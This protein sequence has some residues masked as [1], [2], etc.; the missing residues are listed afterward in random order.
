[1]LIENFNMNNFYMIAGFLLSMYACVSNDIIQTLGTFLSANNKTNFGY[2]WLFASVV[3][4]VTITTGWFVN[5]GDMS[6]GLL[7]RIPVTENFSLLYLLPPII[8]IFLTRWGI[9]VATTFLVLSVFSVSD[10]E[11]IWMMLTKSVLGYI[12]AFFAAIVIYNIIARPLERY[13]YYTQKRSGNNKISKYWIVAKWFSTAFIW[14]QWLVQDSAKLFVYLPR[15]ASAW[16][17]IFVL[18]CFVAYLGILTYNRGG[19]IQ[20]IVKMKTNVQ[21]PRSATIIDIIY[22]CLLLYFIN[23]NNVPMSTTWVFIGLLA[24]REVALYQ[25]LRFESPK[26]MYK[27]ILN[28]LTKV[29]VG[30]VVSIV[31][32]LLL[33]QY[34]SIIEYF[35]SHFWVH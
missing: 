4:V 2:L 9:P 3:L 11:V 35:V 14:S 23:L 18:V 1:M 15:K 26:K 5:N 25:R 27:H 13:F 29:T 10:T 19:D 34:N 6:F 20:K 17:L 21:D 12:I 8:L 7:T 32:V 28:D 30:L 31:V 33:T 22:A 24:G 16:E